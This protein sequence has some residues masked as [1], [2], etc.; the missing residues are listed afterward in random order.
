MNIIRAVITTVKINVTKKVIA[1]TPS[2]LILA[3][4]SDEPWD[5][6]DEPWDEV[7]E[8]WD[9]VVEPWDET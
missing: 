9:E 1:I 3:L 2:L 7:V 8:P 5:K 6:V 4:P